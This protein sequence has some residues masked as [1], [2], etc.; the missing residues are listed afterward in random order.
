MRKRGDSVLPVQ[1]EYLNADPGG[2]IQINRINEVLSKLLK[3]LVRH[4]IV[5]PCLF[6]CHKTGYKLLG[7]ARSPI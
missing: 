2:V 6:I 4:S 5:R 7:L 1:T 3:N